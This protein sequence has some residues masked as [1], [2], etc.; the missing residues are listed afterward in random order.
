M[1]PIIDQTIDQ[2]LSADAWRDLASLLSNLVHA[3]IDQIDMQHESL[4]R[5]LCA[6]T[7]SQQC[8]TFLILREPSTLKSRRQRIFSL[9]TTSWRPYHVTYYNT[10]EHVITE[11]QHFMRR[12]NHRLNAGIAMMMMHSG[13]NRVYYAP[14]YGVFWETWPRDR[15]MRI[16]NS[17]DR[18]GAVFSLDEHTEYCILLDRLEDDVGGYTT[19]NRDALYEALGAIRPFVYRL[20]LS[21]GVLTSRGQEALTDREREALFLL[22]SE[23][24]EKGMA[25]IMGVSPQTMHQYVV[26]VYRKLNV[27]SRAELVSMWMGGCPE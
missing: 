8:M 5:G 6:L 22:F 1:S 23:H 15:M 20:C 26:S 24:S 27:G 10:P 17:Y 12:S 13:K 25:D 18:L 14:D 11:S 9:L 2:T 3:P 19:Q 7:G 21:L 4:C 16:R